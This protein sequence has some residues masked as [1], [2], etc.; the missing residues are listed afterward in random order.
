LVPRNMLKVW[1]QLVEG[2]VSFQ[3]FTCL[4]LLC[5]LNIL[6]VVLKS[7]SI[8]NHFIGFYSIQYYTPLLCWPI[9]SL[10]C[11]SSFRTWLVCYWENLKTIS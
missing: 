8:H 1:F 9:Y 3:L 5:G 4:N 6:Y 11:L 7:L 2:Q 10:F